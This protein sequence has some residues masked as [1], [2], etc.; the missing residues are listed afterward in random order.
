MRRREFLATLTGCCFGGAELAKAQAAP[1]VGILMA[2]SRED[3]EAQSWVQTFVEALR[4]LT[5]TEIEIESEWAASAGELHMRAQKLV[6][7]N[8]RVLI[9]GNTPALRALRQTAPS[10]PIVFTNVA[11]PVGQGVADSLARP[12][13]NITGFGAF[14]F[15]LGG[16]W[17]QVIKEFSPETER[18]VAL[19]NE[20][21]APFWPLFMSFVE[22][23]AS[24]LQLSVTRAQISSRGEFASVIRAH[25][26]PP[27]TAL[28]IFPAAMF[29]NNRDEIIELINRSRAPA[30]YSYRFWAANGGLMSYGVDV[31]D[32]FR[33]AASYVAL[34]LR[35]RPAIELPIQQ[36]TKLQFV[37]NLKTAKALGLTIPP[38][39]LARA[40]EVIE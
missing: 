40:D 16:K 25:T 18:L 15:S 31:H 33:R 4:E 10:V 11:D 2:Y 7:R 21:T 13:G 39:L 8:P 23:A 19:Y 24:S 27:H 37:I 38:T 32:L 6:G 5:S 29:T 22:T 36:P 34:I 17:V 20:A 35:G 1:R 3:Q 30:I 28:V 14:E 12:S 26:Q 9:A